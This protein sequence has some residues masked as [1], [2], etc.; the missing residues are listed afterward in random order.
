MLRL[1]MILV[2][3]VTMVACA[4]GGGGSAAIGP[5][6]GDVETDKG[7]LTYSQSKVSANTSYMKDG[8]QVTITYDHS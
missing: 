6:D 2:V 5:K 7:T 3:M 4:G 8:D 1:A